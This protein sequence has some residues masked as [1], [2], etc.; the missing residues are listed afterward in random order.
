MQY[1]NILP[2]NDSRFSLI[3]K[4]ESLP[5]LTDKRV[6]LT[7][8]DDHFDFTLWARAVRKQMVESLQRRQQNHIG[9]KS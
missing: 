5:L 6:S 1:F 4:Q 3:P 9:T 7:P 2:E 8:T